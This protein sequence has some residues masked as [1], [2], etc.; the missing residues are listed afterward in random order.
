MKSDQR[1]LW[2][3]KDRN[4]RWSSNFDAIPVGKSDLLNA[5]KTFPTPISRYTLCEMNIIWHMFGGN[6]FTTT[7]NKSEK[8]KTVNF[9]SEKTSDYSS[10]SQSQQPQQQPT[11]TFKKNDDN[12]KLTTA[13][14]KKVPTI[15]T[16]KTAGGP[17]RNHDILMEFQLNKVRFRHE[18]YPEDSIQASRQMLLISELEIRDRLAT[19]QINKFLYQYTTEA[20]PKRAQT[21]MVIIKQLFVRPDAHLKREESVLRISLLPLR[22]NIDQDALLFLIAFFTDLCASPAEIG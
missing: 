15:R 12:I 6:D 21:N 10:D 8:N 9:A 22:L 1:T 4:A 2:Y 3:N 7:D 5:P 14:S 19:S 17:D 11:A 13:S 16:W 20:R 18:V